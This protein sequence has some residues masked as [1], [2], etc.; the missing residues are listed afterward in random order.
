[1]GDVVV[2]EDVPQPVSALVRVRIRSNPLE[3]ARTRAN[4]RV[5]SRVARGI[6]RRFE[7]QTRKRPFPPETHFSPRPVTVSFSP[8]PQGELAERVEFQS[9]TCDTQD[10]ED[11][12]FNGIF[13]DVGASTSLPFQYIEIHSLWVRGELGPV[14]VHATPNSHRG[15][16]APARDDDATTAT[17]DA[18]GETR[19]EEEEEEDEDEDEDD[20]WYNWHHAHDPRLARRRGGEIPKVYDAR[21]W[22]KVFDA[23]LEPSFDELVELKLSEP[24]TVAGG[25]TVGLYVHSA[26]PGDRGVV[27]DDARW[28]DDDAHS[29]DDGKLVIYHGTAHLSKTPFGHRAPWG[30]DALRVRRQFVGRVSYA[31]RWMRWN[32]ETH[33]RFPFGFR[34]AV[35]TTLL[36]ARSTEKNCYLTHLGDEIVFYIMNKCG[37]DWFGTNMRDAETEAAIKLEDEAKAEA[38][39][40]RRTDALAEM[41]NVSPEEAIALSAQMQPAVLQ[42]LHA[43]N[44]NQTMFAPPPTTTSGVHPGGHP[45]AEFD[46][47]FDD[48]ETDDESDDGGDVYEHLVSYENGE[49]DEAYVLEVAVDS[50]DE[51]DEEEE[52][53]EAAAEADARRS[54]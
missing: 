31:V 23:T 11:H 8:P 21:A 26:L 39:K 25:D 18:D 4:P 2:A 22:T 51:G 35:E 10:R 16:F 29:K 34:K 28:S 52:E 44:Y 14:T 45:P 1:M 19:Q 20:G 5:V 40:K 36:C 3:P 24:I 41:F 54:V 46:A 13:F 30:G 43:N 32:P 48:E 38:A 42:M 27:Y 50:S 47:A 33:D 9:F 53:E 12:T 37:W 17:D 6:R 7:T 15:N 49:P